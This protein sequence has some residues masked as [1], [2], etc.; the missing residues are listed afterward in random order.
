MF[1][2]LTLDQ[3]PPYR[4]PLRYY[5]TSAVYLVVF[6]VLELMYLKGVYSRF[7]YELIATIHALTIGFFAQVMF[8]SSFQMLPVILGT[9]Y[10]NVKRD[11]NIVYGLLNI[12]VVLFIAGFL[13]N[14]TPLIHTG[15]TSLLIGFLYF[16]YIS[17]STVFESAD[18]SD[19]VQ[20]FAAAYAMLFIASVFGFM[21]ILGHSGV[22]DAVKFGDIHMAFMLLGYLFILIVAVSMKIIPMFFVAKEFPKILKE[23]FYILNIVFLFLFLFFRI[24]SDDKYKIFIILSALLVIVFSIFS[25]KH[26]Y[27]RRRARKDLTITFWYFSMIN[28][29][30]GLIIFIVN[31]FVDVD[32]SVFVGFF[33]LFGGV[34]SLVNGML[35]KIVPFLTWF[36]LSSNFVMEAEMN[37]VIEQRYMRYQFYIY[38]ASYISFF[39]VVFNKTFLVVGSFFFM[40][41]SVLFLRNL[42]KAYRY[43]TKMIQ[44][45]PDFTSNMQ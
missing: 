9:P 1:T 13:T 8:G 40:L 15:G 11:A 27:Q 32:L 22:F 41:S 35:Y 25:L 38:I 45:K 28:I 17:F 5:I 10:E 3:A 34:Y 16:A 44:K 26:I 20:N 2:G 33:I 43:Y 23:K 7:E 14:I 31:F 19:I 12:G 37:D 39:G 4:V 21:A 24:G 6:S 18:K 36:H 29:I 30:V 42:V